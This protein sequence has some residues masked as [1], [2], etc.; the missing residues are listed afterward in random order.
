MKK[1]N[2]TFSYKC[3]RILAAWCAV[4][5][6]CISGY[7][8][9]H[10]Y[11]HHVPPRL[12]RPIP[13]YF[14]AMN[15]DVSRALV[16]R[17]LY[18]G[19]K[20]PPGDYKAWNQGVVTAMK[21]QFHK[22]CSLLFQGDA[23][24]VKRVLKQNK[25]WDRSQFDK[26]FYD[27]TIYGNCAK[28]RSEFMHNLYTT[29]E[30]LDF[31]LAFSMNVYENPQQ[32]LRFLKVIY[33]PHNLYCLHY[34]QKSSAAFK[35]VIKNLAKC[36]G[37]VII[38]PKIYNVV[39]GCYT[40]IEAQ[41]SC[42]RA[43]YAARDSYPWRYAISLCGKELPLR[44]N[45]EIVE[46]LRRL[47]GTSAIELHPMRQINSEI[48]ERFTHKFVIGYDNKCHETR[49]YLGPVPHGL[50][51]KKNLAYIAMSPEF[52]HFLLHNK[53][54]L[55]LYEYMKGALIAEEHYYSTIFWMKGNVYKLASNTKSLNY[56]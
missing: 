55:D 47:N 2:A 36:F 44:T 20:V 17:Q 40:N 45:R 10:H 6:F 43:L 37:N 51:I 7:L 46:I 18:N 50:E 19:C 39:W 25:L 27:Q 3:Y 14:D 31:P 48:H 41:I 8:S 11:Y 24:E 35:R 13:D 33:R 1:T 5:L 15:E 38:P 9:L 12:F 29:R 53:T 52:V 26:E 4:S 22:N 28:I 42:T 34:D 23:E 16:E 56:M 49:E 32:I 54:A 30:E 21:P